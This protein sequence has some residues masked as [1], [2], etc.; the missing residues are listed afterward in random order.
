MVPQPLYT[1][2]GIQEGWD[3]RSSILFFAHGRLG[4]KLL[5]AENREFEGINDWG[6][7]VFEELDNWDD[8]SFDADY[9]SI[10]IRVHVGSR[11]HRLPTTTQ[12][13]MSCL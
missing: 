7:P 10:M 2:G 11:G 13:P 9:P 6:E 1:Y 5:D 12:V 4:V 3:R 8:F